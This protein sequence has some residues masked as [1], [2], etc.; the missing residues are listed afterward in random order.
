MT[1]TIDTLAGSA[2]LD[3]LYT[4]LSPLAMLAGWNKPTPSLYPRPYKTFV[5]AH[6]SYDDGHAALEAAGRL[7]DTSLAERRNLILVNPVEGNE[8][9]TSRTLVAAYQM[10]LPGERART[11][12]HSPNALRLILD[13]EPGTYT[14]VD[15]DKVPMLNNDIVLTPKGSW[16]G[17]G[18]DSTAP[19]YWIDFL[20]VPLVQLLEPM[21]FDAYPED[22]EPASKDVTES[23][24]LFPWST[25][26]S[27]VKNAPLE[28]TGRYGRQITLEHPMRTFG[29]NVMAI[30]GGKPT[31]TVHTT[32]NNIY[33]VIEGS[34]TSDID[35]TQMSWKRGDVFVAPAWRP[36]HHVAAGD[37]VL[38]RVTDEPVLA[39]LDLYQ[40]AK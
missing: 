31:E 12:R 25:I 9:G 36:H 24:L 5:P 13:S 33:A 20:D 4:K 32:A 23:A 37:A 3:D 29:L 11:H 18:N 27:R 16:H 30:A 34:G 8:Y 19:S 35:G 7:I 40:E 10:L 17:H 14:V 15:G 6:W 22:D 28:A 21:F 39:V 1:T 26:E 38:F 2:S